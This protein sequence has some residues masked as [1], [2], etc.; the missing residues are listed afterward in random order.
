MLSPKHVGSGYVL[1]H[2][3]MGIDSSGQRGRWSYVRGGMGGISNALEKVARESGVEIMLETEV[4]KIDIKTLGTDKKTGEIRSQVVGV[5]LSNGEYIETPLVASNATPYHTMLELVDP[6]MLPAEYISSLRSTDYVSPVIKIN[7]AVDKL[8]QFKARPNA[9]RQQMWK[10]VVPQHINYSLNERANQ[11]IGVEHFGTIHLGPATM[12]E[13]DESFSHSSL[14]ELPK[15]PIIEMTIPSTIDR[16]IVPDQTSHVI[17]LFCQYAPEKPKM[18]PW[19]DPKVKEQFAEN[20]FDSIEQYAP[21]F[22]SSIVGK[23]ILSP[24]DLEQIYGLKGGNIFHGSMGL[25]NLY[26]GRP[27]L[28]CPG[29]KTPI[30]GL[31]ICGSGSHPGGGVTGFP[32]VVAAESLSQYRAQSK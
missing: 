2:H 5:R 15:N 26:S 29:P 19:S 9:L 21:G 32:A 11:G 12:D 31:F 6:E 25:E 8:P 23:D 24:Y 17:N 14:G 22:K 4:T 20:V 30:D 1:L 18:G 7:L 16:T 10:E 13:M 28:S 3:V 27:A